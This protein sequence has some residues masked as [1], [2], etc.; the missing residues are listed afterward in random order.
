MLIIDGIEATKKICELIYNGKLISLRK[1]LWL[2]LDMMTM[3][4]N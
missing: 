1:I 3:K 4:Q 2:V